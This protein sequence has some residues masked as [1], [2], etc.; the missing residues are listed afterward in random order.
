M[1]ELHSSVQ[2]YLRE[3]LQNFICELLDSDEDCEVDP[4]KLNPG[5]NLSANQQVLIKMVKKVWM[6]I[7]KS[8]NRFPR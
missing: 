6:D 2:Q 4:M 8:W 7:L 1:I 3:T 5:A